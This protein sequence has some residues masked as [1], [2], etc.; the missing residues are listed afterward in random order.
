MIEKHLR[1]LGQ[2]VRIDILK[3]LNNSSIPLSFS[4]LQREICDINQS[5]INLSFHLKTLKESDL[6]ESIE[7]GYQI[8]ILGKK[9]L[10]N[11]I[12]ME[13]ILNAQNKT[14]MIRTSKYSK[15]PFNIKKI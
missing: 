11:I 12:L 13:Q 4:M 1:I 7:E 15:E 2:K 5:N 14:I 6:I 10:N 9:I 3:K 8:S